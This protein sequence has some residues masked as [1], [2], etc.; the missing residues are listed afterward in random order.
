MP[1]GSAITT[2][3]ALELTKLDGRKEWNLLRNRAR[4]KRPLFSI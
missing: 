2:A 1:P 4:G 3:P